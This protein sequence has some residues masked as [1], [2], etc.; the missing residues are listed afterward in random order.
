MQKQIL[1]LIPLL[2]L[3][4]GMIGSVK[5]AAASQEHEL[6]EMLIKTESGETSSPEAFNK[7]NRW[8]N[9]RGLTCTAQDRGWEE[10]W[11][12]HRNCRAC[13]KH[14]G[15]CIET[16]KENYYICTVE[17]NNYDNTSPR[18]FHARARRQ[19]RAEER[20]MNKCYRSY[21]SCILKGCDSESEVV[22]RRKCR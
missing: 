16:C 6:Q 3:S 12:G 17:G 18:T 5:K 19:W 7:F 8:S 1:W 13:L 22:S 9:R 20:A 2:Y 21:G 14:H 15:R 4:I 10:H 11:G